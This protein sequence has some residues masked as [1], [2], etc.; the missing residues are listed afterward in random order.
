MSSLLFRPWKGEWIFG[1][2][3]HVLYGLPTIARQKMGR[4]LSYG[5]SQA[6]GS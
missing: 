4:P 2:R 6:I 1:L 3:M 5:T